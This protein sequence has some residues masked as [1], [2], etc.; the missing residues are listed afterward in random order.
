MSRKIKFVPAIYP[1][2][3]VMSQCK[4]VF[5]KL[6]NQFHNTKHILGGR[7]SGHNFHKLQRSGLN[8]DFLDSECFRQGDFSTW[9]ML[10]DDSHTKA[11]ISH[12][13]GLLCCSSKLYCIC[14]N[15]AAS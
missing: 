5:H 8:P 12:I 14:I 4:R 6:L 9:W 2:I 3:I 1:I 10:M 15:H 7:R 11:C 13:R